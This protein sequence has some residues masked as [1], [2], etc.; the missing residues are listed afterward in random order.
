MKIG[1]VLSS[2]KGGGSERLHIELSKHLIESG[3]EVDFILL[4]AEKN[5]TGLHS[6]LPQS[7]NVVAINQSRIRSAIF[8]LQETLNSGCYDFVMVAQW[9]LTI[10]TYIA[11]LFSTSKAK[12][13]FTE[14]TNLS[15]SREDELGVP[16]FFL[17]L[18]IYIFYRFADCIIAVSK[19]IRDDLYKLGVKNKNKISVIYNPVSQEGYTPQKIGPKD[20]SNLWKDDYPIKLLAVGSLKKQKNF[21][22]LIKAFSK[23]PNAKKSI[24]QLTILGDGIEKTEIQKLILDLNLQDQIILRG[25]QLDPRPWFDSADLFILSSSWEG[26]GNVLVE[27]MQSSVPIVSTDCQS[28]PREILENGKYG[29]LVEPNNPGALAEGILNALNKDHDKQALFQRSQEFTTKKAS[30]QYITILKKLA[31]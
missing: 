4:N 28:G 3:I 13:I 17:K 31:H 20:I 7:C 9:P 18:S 26:F 6:L 25:F 15:A 2:L 24:S 30:N 11:F 21:P 14:H 19:G 8:P 10:A 16:L 5:Q 1:I 29:V 23:L 22:N 12:I 27:A